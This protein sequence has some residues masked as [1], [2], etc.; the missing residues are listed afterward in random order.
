MSRNGKHHWTLEVACSRNKVAISGVK[1]VDR[2]RGEQKKKHRE[3]VRERE[4]NKEKEKRTATE[5]WNSKGEIH[6]PR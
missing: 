2:E 3:G 4:T 6:H 1:L 5:R